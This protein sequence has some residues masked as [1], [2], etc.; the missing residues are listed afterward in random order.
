MWGDSTD[1]CLVCFW[2]AKRSYCGR[3]SVQKTPCHLS[4]PAL[5]KCSAFGPLLEPNLNRSPAKSLIC[6]PL[7]RLGERFKGFVR[8]YDSL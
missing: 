2:P 3:E 6:K 7:H 8:R 4:Y 5:L 1:R